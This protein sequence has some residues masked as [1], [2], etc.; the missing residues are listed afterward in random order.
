MNTTKPDVATSLDQD[1]RALRDAT[2]KLRALEDEQL[3]MVTGGTVGTVG[4]TALER[5]R[6][7]NGGTNSNYAG[8]FGSVGT[9]R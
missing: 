5:G 4:D 7:T 6:V 2:V 8:G 1:S 3:E 9:V